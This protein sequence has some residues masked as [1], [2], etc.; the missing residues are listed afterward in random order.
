MCAGSVEKIE[1]LVKSQDIWA[2]LSPFLLL[3]F[4]LSI[5]FVNFLWTF[6]IKSQSWT[7][8]ML[9]LWNI[10]VL[11]FFGSPELWWLMNITL[12]LLSFQITKTEK[13]SVSTRTKVSDEIK[14]FYFT[15]INTEKCFCTFIKMCVMMAARPSRRKFMNSKQTQWRAEQKKKNWSEW[16]ILFPDKKSMLKRFTAD[17][18]LCLSVFN[19]KWNQLQLVGSFFFCGCW[20]KGLTYTHTHTHTHT[21]CCCAI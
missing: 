5:D 11:D 15:Q 16:N 19:R 21:L 1:Q 6:H 20:N 9:L 3:V 12:N 4:N 7:T 2:D 18:R 8:G 17:G 10:C 14:Y 13:S